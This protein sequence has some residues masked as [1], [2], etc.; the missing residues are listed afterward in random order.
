M[1]AAIS[2]RRLLIGAALVLY[3][4][5]F[6][7]FLLFEV[8]GLGIGHFYY[9]AIAVVALASGACWGAAAGC[10][11]A[12]LYVAGVLLNHNMHSLTGLPNTRGFEAAITRRLDAGGPFA[13]LLGDLDGLKRI[14]DER[15]YLEG[16]EALRRLA[17]LLNTLLSPEDELTRV[18]GDEFALLTR[19]A[20]TDEAGRV[21]SR[22]ES[23]LAAGGARMTFGWA[24][25]PHDGPNAL[26]LYRAANERL[27]ARRLITG[28]RHEDA[29]LVQSSF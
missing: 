19:H 8:P 13:L 20:T 15:G 10:L 2:H 9:V 4:V 22:L 16:D 11:G 25:Y 17:D 27:Y 6:A 14:N 23:V 24:V 21:C 12:A 7:A 29:V 28:R 1:P 3:A 26:S 5:I 18:G